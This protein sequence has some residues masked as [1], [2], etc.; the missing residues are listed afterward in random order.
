LAERRERALQTAETKVAR[1]QLERRT[2]VTELT[3]FEQ[4]LNVQRR[5]S[6][7]FGVELQKLKAEQQGSAVEHAGELLAAE[8]KVRLSQDRVHELEREMADLRRVR[9]E[10]E[11]KSGARTTLVYTISRGT[12][13]WQSREIQTA[14]EQ[15]KASFKL[16][17]HELAVQIRYLKAKYSRESTLRN[18]LSLQKKYLLLLVGGMSLK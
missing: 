14:L 16:Q 3:D 4:D 12:T 15:Q 17:T 13:S 9:R 1:L 8:R 7:R 6:Q 18:G 5:E 11:S 2:I 10:L